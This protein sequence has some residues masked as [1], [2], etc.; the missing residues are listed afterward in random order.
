MADFW[1]HGLHLGKEEIPP[2]KRRLPGREP[3]G[4]VIIVVCWW[5][6]SAWKRQLRP[7]TDLI[8]WPMLTFRLYEFA[9]SNKHAAGTVTLLVPTHSTASSF[10]WGI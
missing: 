3:R 8:A 1:F 9:H 5:S 7:E 2:I 4:M 10:T 6:V